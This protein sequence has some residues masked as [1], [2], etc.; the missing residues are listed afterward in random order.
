MGKDGFAEV[1]PT[2]Q[3]FTDC[4]LKP[5]FA[6]RWV[7]NSTDGFANN[8]G[9][10]EYWLRCVLAQIVGVKHL[11]DQPTKMLDAGCGPAI[12]TAHIRAKLQ[13]QAVGVDYSDTMLEQAKQFVAALPE[14]HRVEVMKGDVRYLQFDLLF[15]FAGH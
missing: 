3:D 10:R 15:D 13:C 4:W 7:L 6:K 9:V 12:R 11:C 8:Q 2:R 5:G 14:E 1:A